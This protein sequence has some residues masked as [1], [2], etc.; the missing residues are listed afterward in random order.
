MSAP[1]APEFN[2]SE[3]WGGNPLTTDVNAQ[4][5]GLEF[6]YVYLAFCCFV[7]WL[8][9]PGIGLLYGGLARRKSSLSLLFQSIMVAAVT[10][11]QW[12]F[13]VSSR[14]SSSW[15]G[16]ELTYSGLLAGILKVRKRVYW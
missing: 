5:A 4:Y 16:H 9:I 14:I 13:W 8:I 2:S 10:T 12:M 1:T 7:V 6:H 11:F 15:I 3:P